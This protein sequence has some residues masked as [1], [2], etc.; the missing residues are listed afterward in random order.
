MGFTPE[1]I[2]RHLTEDVC[3]VNKAR[4]GVCKGVQA[5]N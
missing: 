4:F 2:A 1:G 5:S 3:Q